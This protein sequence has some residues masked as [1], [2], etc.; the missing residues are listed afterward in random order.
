MQSDL[1]DKNLSWKNKTI[2]F[3]SIQ[4]NCDYINDVVHLLCMHRNRRIAIT[5]SLKIC[6]RSFCITT[7]QRKRLANRIC[8]CIW[9]FKAV[10]PCVS[11]S[12]TNSIFYFDYLTICYQWINRLK[13]L[14]TRCPI[15]N[16]SRL[17][18]RCLQFTWCQRQKLMV[19][20][21]WLYILM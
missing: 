5:L 9:C 21:N 13:I 19:S 8:S 4:K 20:W 18:S 1:R 2:F 6:R 16:A 11:S 3:E 14:Q 12:L 7:E 15:Q 10:D 17:G